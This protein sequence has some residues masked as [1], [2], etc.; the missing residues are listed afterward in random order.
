MKARIEVKIPY[1]ECSKAPQ[2]R[3][4][5]LTRCVLMKNQDAQKEYEQRRNRAKQ[6]REKASIPTRKRTLK[7]PES[8]RSDSRSGRLV[9]SLRI[10]ASNRQNYQRQVQWTL[11]FCQSTLTDIYL[12]W[13]GHTSEPTMCGHERKDA[14]DSH[15]SNNRRVQGDSVPHCSSAEVHWKMRGGIGLL[16]YE[17]TL[18]V[19]QC[20]Y[21]VHP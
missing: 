15:F 1:K 21:S 20:Y 19:L 4:V 16:L 13:H 14:Y 12:E 11:D 10:R 17:I 2:K 3:A 5:I 18:L 6:S 8:V 9:R 7:E